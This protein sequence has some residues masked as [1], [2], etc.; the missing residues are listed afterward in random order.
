MPPSLSRHTVPHAYRNRLLTLWMLIC[1]TLRFAVWTT[2]GVLRHRVQLPVS[3]LVSSFGVGDCVFR[4][5]EAGRKGE[6][7]TV[8]K[9]FPFLRFFVTC[10]RS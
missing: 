6:Q 3:G 1:R 8:H 2:A 5:P 4:V 7:K 9:G 10:L